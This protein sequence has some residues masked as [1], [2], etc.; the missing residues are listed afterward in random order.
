MPFARAFLPLDKIT[1]ACP[2]FGYPDADPQ[3][4]WLIIR[5]LYVLKQSPYH[6]YDKINSI[7]LA[8]GL[9][10]SHEDPCLYSGFN[11]DPSNL[12]SLPS[13]HPLCL[14]LH[15]DDF[16]IFSKDPE[17]ESL[18]CHLLAKRYKVDFI[19][20]VN[21]FLSIHFSWSIMPS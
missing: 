6:W 12:S 5:T 1:I 10:P 14:G 13:Q 17:V 11:Q 19:W 16:V 7:L 20:I 15:V 3:E 4:C 2:P 21:W 9:C 8:N 18:F